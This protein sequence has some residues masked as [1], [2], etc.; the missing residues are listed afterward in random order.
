MKKVLSL[1]LQFVVLMVA[2]I[3]GWLRE[4]FHVERV[5]WQTAY[6]QRVFAADWVIATLIVYILIL[7]IH[8]LRKRL[9]N[10]WTGSTAVLVLVL[11]SGFVVKLGF[12]T[13]DLPH[14]GL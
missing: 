4:P 1:L 14:F 13:S 8:A 12:R 6:Q 10:A 9:R 7:V 3:F 11:I 5:L 2:A